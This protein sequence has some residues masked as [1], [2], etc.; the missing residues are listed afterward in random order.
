MSTAA[1]PV[2]TRERLVGAAGELFR[3]QGYAA[4]GIKA[5]LEAAHAPYGS[6]YHFFPGGKAELG[7]AVID[8]GARTFEDLVRSHFASPGEVV[9][10]VSSFFEGA[11]LV[12]EGSD[13]ADACPVATFAGEVAA[14]D[15]RMRAAAAAAFGSWID[16]LAE[17]LVTDG[18][19][20]ATARE[21]AT[22]GFCLLEGAFLLARV[23]RDA[24]PVRTAGRAM[25]TLTEQALVAARQLAG[26]R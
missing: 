14:A 19:D 2:P 4:T 8:D 15:E 23:T 26:S 11:A 5:V 21:L 3:R 10:L 9:A 1:T 24:E 12:V 20:A 25:A 6:L 22:N 7:V 18:L 17:R 13:Y 16:A